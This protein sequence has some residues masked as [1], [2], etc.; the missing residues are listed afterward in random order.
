MRHL[1]ARRHGLEVG[2]DGHMVRETYK[3]R[4]VAGF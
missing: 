4:G 2:D 1:Y 3:S